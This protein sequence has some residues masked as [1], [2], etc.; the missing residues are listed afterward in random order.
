MITT[1]DEQTVQLSIN[2]RNMEPDAQITSK[3]GELYAQDDGK[4]VTSY[5]P[6][7]GHNAQTTSEEGEL[8]AQ[9]DGEDA[10]SY[11]PKMGHDAQTTSKEGEQIARDDDTTN[12][13]IGDEFTMEKYLQKAAHYAEAGH[14]PKFH[15]FLKLAKFVGHMPRSTVTDNEA[16][17]A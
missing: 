13:N 3:E 16:K 17:T 14:E 2:V 6:K 5:H 8:I 4:D 1:D 7:M 12:T 11:H 10:T 15:M 9:D